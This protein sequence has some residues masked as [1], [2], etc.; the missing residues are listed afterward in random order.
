MAGPGSVHT[1]KVSDVRHTR[2]ASPLPM[3]V[4]PAESGSVTTAKRIRTFE[5]QNL[6]YNGN[7]RVHRFESPRSRNKHRAC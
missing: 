5:A 4:S 6:R 7:L 1:D 3:W 2:E